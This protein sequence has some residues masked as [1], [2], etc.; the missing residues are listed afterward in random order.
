[1]TEKQLIKTVNILLTI[2]AFCLLYGVLDFVRKPHT[3]ELREYAAKHQAEPTPTPYPDGRQSNEVIRINGE[4]RDA[5]M[6]IDITYTSIHYDYICR[7]YITAYCAEECNSDMTA[8]GVRCHWSPDPYEPVTV[9]IDRRFYKFGDLFWIDGQMY[10]AEDTGS[11]VLGN[12]WDVYKPD[13]AS[14]AAFGSHYSDV[15]R[16]S[17]QTNVI[18]SKDW[19]EMYESTQYYFHFGGGL[20]W[21][22]FGD[23]F[24]AYVRHKDYQ[25]VAG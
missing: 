3:A 19:R 17:Y 6:S 23:G 13:Y 18:K 8:S 16:V 14:M 20:Y 11:A 10:V 21:S 4:L 9:A 22:V 1:M 12:H 25:R 5:F 7:G 24:G 2:A 15:Y